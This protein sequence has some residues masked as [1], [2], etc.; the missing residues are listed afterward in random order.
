MRRASSIRKLLLVGVIAGFAS[1]ANATTI[2][3]SNHSSDSTTPASALS[4]TLEFVV[5]GT[6]LMLTVNNQS[7]FEITE[8]YFNFPDSVTTL[9]ETLL[10]TGWSLEFD[11]QAAQFGIF[12]AALLAGKKSQTAILSSG[13]GTFTLGIVGTGPFADYHF[14]NEHTEVPPGDLRARAAAKFVAG[15]EG[16]EGGYGAATPEPNGAVLFGVG[17]LILGLAMRRRGLD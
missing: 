12:D 3:L 9:T 4:A 2:E 16:M 1:A 6:E 14:A 5:S 7:E 15:P 8:I 11:K 13:T 17:C 10:P